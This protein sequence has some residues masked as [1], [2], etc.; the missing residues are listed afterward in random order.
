MNDLA[1][2]V[3]QKADGKGWIIRSQSILGEGPVGPRLAKGSPYPS[4]FGLSFSTKSEA[5]AVAEKWKEWYYGQK[6]LQKKRKA[7]YIA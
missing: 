6:Y 5:D 4:E 2:V 7:K 1:F 3:R